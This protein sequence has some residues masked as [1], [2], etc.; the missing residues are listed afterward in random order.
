MLTK[1][2]IGKI[3][4]PPTIVNTN[5]NSAQ[6]VIKMGLSQQEFVALLQQRKLVPDLISEHKVC[7]LHGNIPFRDEVYRGFEASAKLGEL[8]QVVLAGKGDL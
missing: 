8:T 6:V 2:F 7:F 4:A 5:F 1:P 3:S